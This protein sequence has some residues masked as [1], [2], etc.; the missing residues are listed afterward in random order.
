MPLRPLPLLLP[1]CAAASPTPPPPRDD[2]TAAGAPVSVQLDPWCENSIRVRLRPAGGGASSGGPATAFSNAQRH[3]SVLCLSAECTHS[4]VTSGYTRGAVEGYAPGSAV[5]PNETLA[6]AVYYKHSTTDNLVGLEAKL[7][8]SAQGYKRVF[9]NGATLKSAASVA[10]PTK[11]LTLYFN[12]QTQHSLTTTATAPPGY[13]KLQTLGFLCATEGCGRGPPPPPTAL[14]VLTQLPGALREECLAEGPPPPPPLLGPG[15]LQHGNLEATVSLEAGALAVRFARASDGSELTTARPSFGAIV[16]SPY[17]QM[18]LQL[19]GPR[20]GASRV[21]GLGEVEGTPAQ[22]GC[23]GN[24]TT[25]HALLLARNGLQMP[26][27]ASKF[28]I[29]LPWAYS[30][31]A[32]FGVLVNAP[33]DGTV[34][35]SESG[36]MDWLLAS[37]QEIYFWMTTVAAP[38]APASCAAENEGSFA[39]SAAG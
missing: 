9:G 11:A 31:E 5:P 2:S 29:G 35:V 18:T 4:E 33:G 12:S 1:L 27:A 14:P 34:N 21:F 30:V 36:A 7:P 24:G 8:G 26:L 6:L 20:S 10:G 3:D 13:E 19:S 28:H 37:P 15:R 16:S 38:D 39:A 25:A 23:D 32:G 22:G 17:R